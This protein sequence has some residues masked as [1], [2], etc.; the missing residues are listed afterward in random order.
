[1]GGRSGI[2]VA[3]QQP[4]SV[5]TIMSGCYILAFVLFAACA[6]DIIRTLF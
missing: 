6:S 4:S 2:E 5:R 3:G 1:M